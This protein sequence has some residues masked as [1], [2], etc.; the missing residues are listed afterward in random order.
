MGS[1]GHVAACPDVDPVSCAAGDLP[2]H[3][4]DLR[5]LALRGRVGLGVGLG[6]PARGVGGAGRRVI[7]AASGALRGLL[8]R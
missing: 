2:R 8:G 1:A 4:H 3:R 6:D 7:D 5:N